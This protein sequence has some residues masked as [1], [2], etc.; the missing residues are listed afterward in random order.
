MLLCVPLLLLMMAMVFD[1]RHARDTGLD[2]DRV[3]GMAVVGG[4]VRV[5][6]HSLVDGAQRRLAWI[7]HRSRV[8]FS[9]L[10]SVAETRS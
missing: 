7:D 8:C 1:L 6:E 3:V 5:G 4:C 9:M 10:S 2:I